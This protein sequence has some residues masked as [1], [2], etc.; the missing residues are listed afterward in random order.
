[1]KKIIVRLKENS[2]PILISENS[3][4][5]LIDNLNSHEISKCLILIDKNVE[6]YH[7]QYLRKI[8]AGLNCKSYKYIFNATELNKNLKQCYNIF[9]FLSSHY[10]DRNSSIVSVGGG[11]A[12]DIAGF[13]AS[14]FMRG[15]GYYQVPTTLLSMVD[16]SVGGKTGVN[17]E[18]RKNYIGTFY[19]PN[20]VY[21]N[22]IFLNSL[23]QRE[24]ISGIGEIFKYSF[25]SD[26]KNYSRLKRDLESIIKGKKI[27][28]NGIIESCLKIKSNIV[29][30]DEKEILGLR[31]ILNLGHT[32]A[33]AFEVQSNYKLKHG[34]AVIG[35]VFCSLFLS[36]ESGYISTDQLKEFINDYKFITINK[37]LNNLDE[38][39]IYQSMMSDKKN[40]SGRIK[41]VLIEDV[42][43]IIVDVLADKLLILDSIKR[44]KKLV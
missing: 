43:K 42:G 17:F 31:K 2:Y 37:R 36:E 25:L 14:T 40:L 29:S 30:Q 33:H 41:F 11:I 12:G 1:M 39:K 4:S 44:M 6:K 13:T 7:S 23:P 16:S 28:Y 38:E 22:S 18:K 10:F 9:K 35:G 32:F 19:Q 27:N 20:G 24:M 5:S 8:F 34:E 21:I 3:L 15:I 26:Y